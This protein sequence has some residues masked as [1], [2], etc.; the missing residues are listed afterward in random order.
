MKVLPKR[1]DTVLQTSFS[2]LQ[3]LW[4][5]DLHRCNRPCALVI[6]HDQRAIVLE[7]GSWNNDV[8][9]NDFIKY[10]ISRKDLV[11]WIEKTC[12]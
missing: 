12:L 3:K 6:G 7:Q 10:S 9:L 1:P 8:T 11:G 2:E 5:D 4:L